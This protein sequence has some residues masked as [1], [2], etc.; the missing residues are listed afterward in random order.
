[1][2]R[3]RN[4]LLLLCCA[5]AAS[6]LV[7]GLISLLPPAQQLEDH[8]D[9]EQPEP[10]ATGAPAP[11]IEAACRAAQSDPTLTDEAR[12]R[13]A[14]DT[15]FTLKYES[16]VRGQA[17]DLAIVVDESTKAGKTLA[18]YELGRLQYSLLWWRE[19]GHLTVAYDYHPAYDAVEVNGNTAV[20]RI[21][22]LVSLHHD[23]SGRLYWE[24][25]GFEL[26]TLKLAHGASGWRVTADDYRDEFKTL[27]PVGT[28]WAV[29]QARFPETVAQW[30]QQQAE[31]RK[32]Q[33]PR[34]T[35]LPRD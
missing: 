5:V 12:V 35:D 28:A 34:P 23:D 17:L 11:T 16:L 4:L 19:L 25:G 30:R 2:K 8:P 13:S 18:D 20:V 3:E 1:M 29:L 9:V 26:H 6:L 21:R 33:G 10:A 32:T 14:V 27:H 22:P 15:Y 31:L 24:P 7:G